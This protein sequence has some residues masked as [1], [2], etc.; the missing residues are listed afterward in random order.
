MCEG[1]TLELS[2]LSP[3]PSV[4]LDS[5]LPPSLSELSIKHRLPHV[6][7][8]LSERERGRWGGAVFAC[9]LKEVET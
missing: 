2:S 3:L 6:D 1:K 9:L 5:S 8:G 7:I 4:H